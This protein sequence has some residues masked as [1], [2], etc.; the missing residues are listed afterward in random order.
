MGWPHINLCCD[1]EVVDELLRF[2]ARQFPDI[3]EALEV[4]EATELDDDMLDN[5][6]RVDT[7]DMVDVLPNPPPPTPPENKLITAINTTF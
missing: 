5:V 6:E 1:D 2:V 7:G 4:D 3:L